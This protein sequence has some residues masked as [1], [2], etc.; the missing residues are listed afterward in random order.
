MNDKTGLALLTAIVFLLIGIVIL[1]YVGSFSVDLILTW[2][3]AGLILAAFVE[4]LHIMI[5][6]GYTRHR[7]R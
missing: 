6:N 3:G 2:I 5:G 1:Y 4:F 7:N